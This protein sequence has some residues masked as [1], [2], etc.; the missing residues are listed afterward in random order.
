ATVTPLLLQFLL[1]PFGRGV[2]QII[3]DML[4]PEWP[5]ASLPELVAIFVMPDQQGRGIGE[6]IC[7]AI[8][9]ELARR[10]I[11]CY[12]VHTE[13]DPNNRAIAFYERLGF[14][15]TEPPNSRYRL[16]RLSKPIP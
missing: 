12:V 11:E 1:K 13:R 2:R 9:A 8:E 14:A 7:L 16:M 6:V 4:H 10:K 15:A 5:T 3:A